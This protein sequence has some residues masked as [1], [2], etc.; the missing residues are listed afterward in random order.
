MN[1]KSK[2]KQTIKEFE[3]NKDIKRVREME[4]NRSKQRWIARKSDYVDK[5]QDLINNEIHREIEKTRG[6]S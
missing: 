6:K 4:R 3:L 1:L 2:L 5:M